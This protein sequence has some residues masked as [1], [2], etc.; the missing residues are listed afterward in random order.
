MRKFNNYP[1]FCHFSIWT[2]DKVALQDDLSIEMCD[3]QRQST[4]V[5]FVNSSSHKCFKWTLKNWSNCGKS[6][7]VSTHFSFSITMLTFVVCFFHVMSGSIY[8]WKGRQVW[9]FVLEIS[10]FVGTLIPICENRPGYICYI[11]F[12]MFFLCQPDRNSFFAHL[13]KGNLPN[14]YSDRVAYVLIFA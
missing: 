2:Y 9:H 13:K 10:P 3:L 5:S 11:V 8:K 14:I 1:N 6:P 12:T 4:S 7:C